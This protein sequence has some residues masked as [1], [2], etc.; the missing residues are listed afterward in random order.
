MGSPLQIHCF[1]K[2]IVSIIPIPAS[3]FSI[4]DVRE[5]TSVILK[6]LEKLQWEAFCHHS[7]KRGK[8]IIPMVRL[9]VDG[10]PTTN[11]F[12]WAPDGNG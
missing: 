7:G 5:N 11:Y 4:Y 8:T 12:E 3:L 6:N 1:S 10:C 2:I 9:V